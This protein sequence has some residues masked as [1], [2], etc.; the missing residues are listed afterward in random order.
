MDHGE[1]LITR[2]VPVAEIRGLV[3]AGQIRHS[4]V[5]VALYYFELRQR[6]LSEKELEPDLQAAVARIKPRSLSFA[7]LL[8]TFSFFSSNSALQGF[9][10]ARQLLLQ[11]LH[12]FAVPLSM[13]LAISPFRNSSRSAILAVHCDSSSPILS[14][15][16]G[17]LDGGGRFAQPFHGEFVGALHTLA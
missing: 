5:V 3:A 11:L 16:G 6:G 8:R 15:V 7:G 4:L 13:A 12:G 17:E 1:D 2:L 9:A 14:S 10:V